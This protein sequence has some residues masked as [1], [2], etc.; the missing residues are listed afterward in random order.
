MGAV[1][2]IANDK[3][4]IAHEL[5]EM[6]ARLQGL[7]A[8]T[9]YTLNQFVAYDSSLGNELLFGMRFTE[10]FGPVITLSAGGIHAEFLSQ[11]LKT[12]HEIA[13]FSPAIPGYEP[14]KTLAVSQLLTESHRGQAPRITLDRLHTLIARFYDLIAAFPHEFSDF[15]INPLVLHQSKLVALDALVKLR[16]PAINIE[17]KPEKPLHKIAKI[18]TPK[19]IALIGVSPSG[20]PGKIILDNLLL[21]GFNREAIFIVKPGSTE[22]AGCRCYPDV[23]ALPECIDLCVLVVS[24]AQIPQLMTQLIQLKKAETMIVI[25]GGLEEKAGSESI[26]A[27]MNTALINSRKNPDQGPLINGG[28]CLGVRSLPGKINTLFIPEYKLPISGRPE[29]PLALLSQ[30]G[31]FAIARLS[32]LPGINPKYTVT[33]GNQTDLTIGDYL[34]YFKNDLSIKTFAVY[35][36][37]FKAL[38]GERFLKAAQ[39]ITQSGRTVLLYRAGRTAAGAEASASHTASIAGNYEVTR[40]LCK[41]AGVILADSLEDFD[42]LLKLSCYLENKTAKGYR[43][44]AVSNAGFECV[45]IADNLNSFTLPPPGPA[46][47]RL[48]EGAFQRSKIGQIVD[49][50]NPFDLTPMCADT[51]FAAIVEALLESPDYDALEVACIPLTPALNT[52]DN[53][54]AHLLVNLNQRTQK[55]WIAIVDSGQLYNE[56]VAILESAQIP[57]FRTADRGL[58]IFAQYLDAKRTTSFSN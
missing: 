5:K 47:T 58:R 54:L 44:G 28:N 7:G 25:P 15:E 49:L 35:V 2:V 32:K 11:Q 40:S 55:P 48:I 9:G 22:I 16:D 13:V 56:F 14:L 24:A 41:Q 38:D 42:D 18:L 21:D 50:H 45:A 46:T 29:T 10:D 30:S 31:A 23:A 27:E 53:S 12:G 51:E 20:G 36:E 37:G 52:T 34:T 6:D 19:N 33:L 43:L 17:P 3:A 57:T 1:R 4:T 8:V 26:V 39:E